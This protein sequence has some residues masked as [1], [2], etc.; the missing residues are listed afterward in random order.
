MLIAKVLPVPNPQVHTSTM[1]RRAVALLAVGCALLTLGWT[2]GSACAVAQ[3][4]DSTTSTPSATT[5]QTSAQDSARARALAAAQAQAAAQAAAAAQAKGK[6]G[7]Q[8]RP[9][10]QV[11]QSNP[12]TPV[13]QSRPATQ[14]TQG[15]P[16]TPVNQNNPAAQVTQDNL[17][18]QVTQGKQAKRGKQ[19]KNVYTGPNTVETLPPKPM[20]DEEGKQ[21]VDPD[22][23]LMFYPVVQQIRDKKGH[24]VFDRAGNP[25][26]QTASNMGY[27]EHGKKIVVKKERQPRRTPVTIQSGTLTVDGWTNKARINFNIPDLKYIYVYVPGIGTTI[28]SPGQFPGATEQAGAFKGNTLQVTVEGH[29]IELTSERTLLGRGSQK[30]WVS[31]DREFV[32]PTK[33]PTIGYGTTI[34][35]PYVWPGSKAEGVEAGVNMKKAPPLPADMVA[36]PLS[37]CPTGMIRKVGPPVQPGQIEPEQPC[38]RMQTSTASAEAATATASS[39][40][41]SSATPAQSPQ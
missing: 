17:A 21:R 25:V 31:V 4:S 16:T 23:K 26:F 5:T 29:P 22:G 20:L 9:A 32:L 6:K 2:M 28:V 27:D 12:A 33:Y 30:A 40:E 10:T 15:N 1:A 3:T 11:K 14:V 41:T 37:P 38:V 36:A 13:T 8:S 7:K 24:P 34:Q 18:T 35:A 19:A 39:A